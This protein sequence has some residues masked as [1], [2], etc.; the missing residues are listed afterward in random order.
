MSEK[1]FRNLDC[2][3]R[4]KCNSKIACEEREKIFKSFWALADFSKQNVFVRGM[5]HMKRVDHIRK[6]NGSRG[7]KAGIF[8]YF[9]RV[10][11]VTISVQK[12]FFEHIAN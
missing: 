5:V 9:L 11:D 7:P 2:H 4:R 10:Q 12:V 3:C 6:R 1:I 8:L